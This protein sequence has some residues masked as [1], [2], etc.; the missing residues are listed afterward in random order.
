MSP[1]LGTAISSSKE[2]HN[3]HPNG[4]DRRK[5]AIIKAKLKQWRNWFNTETGVCVFIAFL[6]MAMITL[7]LTA[8]FLITTHAI[9]AEGISGRDI[10]AD[11][12][13]QVQDPTETQ[14]AR[15]EAKEMVLPIY[16]KQLG[17]DRLLE[18]RLISLIDSLQTIRESKAL[19]TSQK[20][21]KLLS[22][23]SD[24]QKPTSEI[25]DTILKTRQWDLLSDT[26][27]ETLKTLTTQGIN[28]E[29]YRSRRTR[30]SRILQAIPTDISLS[31]EEKDAL[32]FIVGSKLRPTLFIDEA[33]TDR[34]R[35]YAANH[36]Q[37][38]W[39][40]F[41][42]GDLIVKK[43]DR[44]TNIQQAA[45]E[46]QGTL[47]SKHRVPSMLGIGLLAFSLLSIVWGYI[48][49]FERKTFFK[50]AYVSLIA[51]MMTVAVLFQIIGIDIFPQ[52]PFELYP[53]AILPLMISIFTHPRIAMLTS[54]VMLL[55]CGL[56]L[57]VPLQSLSVLVISSLAG[58][59][60][61]ARKPVP[62]DRNDLILAG[63]SVGIANAVSMLAISSIY[64]NAPHFE[65]YGLF[66]SMIFGFIGGIAAGVITA[67]SLT[68]IEGWFKLITPYTLLELGNHNRPI[69]R[70]M[71]LEAPGTFHHSVMVANLAESAA[72]AIGANPILTKVGALYHDI[73]KL[74]RPLFFIENQ[75]YFQVENPHDA[76]TPRL[77]KMVITAHPRD[78][79]EM[80]KQLGLPQ[81]ILR[82]M[83]EHHGTMVAGYFYN[84]AVIEEGEENVNKNQFRY[85]GPKPQSRETAIVMLADACESAV[86]ALKEP[87][88]SMVEGRVDS[89]IRQRIEDD[90][91]DECPITMQEIHMVRDTFLRILRG[92]H[93]QRIEYI[94]AP[95]ADLSKKGL[96]PEINP[97]KPNGASVQAIPELPKSEALETGSLQAE[98][99]ITGEEA[100]C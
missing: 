38:V 45:L 18:N 61:L 16:K 46:Q 43:G 65:N 55:L 83:P 77:S 23:L 12:L 58:I 99:T 30:N 87:S 74:K 70:R 96:I 92:I 66:S 79:I 98:M 24:K 11:T 17:I 81:T 86:R 42:K 14:R 56:A 80:G 2:N 47:S 35:E 15:L 84:K 75:A 97:T 20:E 72:E 50:P 73:G 8:R 54:M 89:I 59:F 88:I 13:L 91:F 31:I 9:D 40:T 5:R 85:P 44:L 21:A 22:L 41:H 26:A 93:H 53:I 27:L 100:G 48:Y 78:G 1:A 7:M 29:E 71:Q 82:F 69:L 25:T 63:I 57:K 28:S 67:G 34:N 62:S 4:D 76:L 95:L 51:T 32:V 64:G 39:E 19:S 10:Y 90:Q 68:I 94:Q 49:R 52:W 33:E 37:P 36:I 60:V 6:S 3:N